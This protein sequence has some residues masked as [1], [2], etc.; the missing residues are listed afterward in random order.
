M[1]I[2]TE[3]TTPRFGTIEFNADDLV[4]FADGLIGFPETKKF[5]ILQHKEGSPFRWLQ[6]V[7]EPNL[8]FLIVDPL[9]Y[10]ADYSPQVNATSVASLELL[11]ETP[12]LVYTIVTIPKGKPSDMTL[13]LAGPLVINAV[14]RKAM[15]VVLD[16]PKWPLKYAVQ[17][18]PAQDSIAA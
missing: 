13:N 3:L 14:N 15:Q 4:T 12:H 9:T 10:C 6:S 5:L 16:D 2:M 7:E 8:A 18:A 1:M 17:R 11:E